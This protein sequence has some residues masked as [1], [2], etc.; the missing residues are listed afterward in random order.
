MI[1]WY[2]DKLE[3]GS[4]VGWEDSS[5]KHFR[6]TPINNLGREIIQNSLDVPNPEMD[7]VKV[8]FQLD[9]VKVSEI[10]GIQKLRELLENGIRDKELYVAPKYFTSM[11]RAKR[12]LNQQMIDI[13]TISE[14][15][16]IGME[17]PCTPKFP[18]YKYMKSDGTGQKSIQN[19]KGSH[20]LGKG[21]AVVCS[22]LNTIFCS[23]RFVKENQEQTLCMGR[24]LFSSFLVDR[25]NEGGS[26]YS[27]KCYWGDDFSPV[28]I[29]PEL[30]SWLQ[31]D[32]VGT[33]III[34]GFNGESDWA[35][36]LLAA[37]CQTYFT[38]FKRGKLEVQID[39][40]TVNSE[41][42][43]KYFNGFEGKGL[44]KALE[45]TEDKN[46][47]PYE[48]SK[49]LFNLFSEPEITENI[50]CD[51]LGEIRCYLV[52]RDDNKK[53]IGLIRDEMFICR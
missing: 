40:Y 43:D 31:R 36:H 23:T 22:N 49:D 8:N 21:A 42:I 18:F 27:G 33:N 25:E 35:K 28:E 19:A 26:S 45:S 1:N 38:A 30:P 10:P 17:G 46:E 6:D 48:T 20:G 29:T 2:V 52:K 24:A 4:A 15:G 9:R 37:T 47:T 3:S 16:T 44:V 13:M 39:R 12:L 5:S 53:S 11:D 34:L 32:T 51:I 14:I 7:F 50:K 41:N